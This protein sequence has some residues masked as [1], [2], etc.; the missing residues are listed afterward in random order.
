MAVFIVLWLW[1]LLLFLSVRKLNYALYLLSNSL[2]R[3]FR[4]F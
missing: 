4:F 3:A 1:F 2:K